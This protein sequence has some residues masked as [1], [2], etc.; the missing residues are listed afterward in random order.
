M[1]LI[2]GVLSDNCIWR[3]FNLAKFKVLLYN[4]KCGLRDWWDFNLV[5]LDKFTKLANFNPDQNFYS[6]NIDHQI[7]VTA[8]KL[9]P[10]LLV[11]VNE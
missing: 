6:Y 8:S 1:G 11:I 3:Y 7:S 5:P 9:L 4:L 10:W 2:F